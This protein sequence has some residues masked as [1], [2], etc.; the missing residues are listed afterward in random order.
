MQAYEN[1]DY[2]KDRITFVS[3]QT[4]IATYNGITH[5]LFLHYNPYAFSPTTSKQFNRWLREKFYDGNGIIAIIKY[6]IAHSDASQI[7]CSYIG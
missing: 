1:F 7:D 5:N 6:Q 2:F 3:Y 4:P